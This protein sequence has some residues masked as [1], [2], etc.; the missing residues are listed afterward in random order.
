MQAEDCE[1]GFGPK[2]VFPAK[3]KKVKIFVFGEDAA[4]RKV[5]KSEVSARIESVFRR[6]GFTV[7]DSDGEY[8]ET[9]IL[10]NVDLLASNDG[11]TLA[12]PL[13]IDIQHYMMGFAGGIWK[14]S[15]LRSGHYSQVI[16]FGSNH[17]YKI[18]GIIEGLAVSASN[19]L[20]KAGPNPERKSSK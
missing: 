18:S 17:F 9:V 15:V 3:D 10:V 2:A 20:A 6:D 14:R 4:F 12:G 11:I 16:S 5:S 13:T 19:D 1:I 7:V 8:C